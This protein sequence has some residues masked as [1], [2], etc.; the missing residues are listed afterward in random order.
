MAPSKSQPGHTVRNLLSAAIVNHLRRV[1]VPW[2]SQTVGFSAIE[3]LKLARSTPYYYLERLWRVSLV[4]L[5]CWVVLRATCR[6]VRRCKVSTDSRIMQDLWNICTVG[7]GFTLAEQLYTDTCVLSGEVYAVWRLA[8]GNAAENRFLFDVAWDSRWL[9]VV[10]AACLAWWISQTALPEVK[11]VAQRVA[12]GRLTRL[13][14]H[15]AVWGGT[16]HL[17]QYSNRYF[18]ALE[19]GDMLMTLVWIVLSCIRIQAP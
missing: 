9:L 6:R 19:V 18:V 3:A 16:M 13:A 8:T 4:S 10:H 14:L 7:L 2:T 1:L 15:C 17:V 5:C 12:K 11:M